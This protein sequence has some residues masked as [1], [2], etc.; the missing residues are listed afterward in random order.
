MNIEPD[1]SETDDSGD[2]WCPEC[3]GDEVIYLSD[4]GQFFCAECRI[5]IEY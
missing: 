3:F 5:I 4:T 1:E 2:E